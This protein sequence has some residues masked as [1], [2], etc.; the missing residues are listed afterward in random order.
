[1]WLPHRDYD[2]E[3][4]NTQLYTIAKTVNDAPRTRAGFGGAA[5]LRA[6]TATSPFNNEG[7]ILGWGFWWAKRARLHAV[8]QT[9]AQFP[10]RP[11][12][13]RFHGRFRQIQNLGCL[14][15]PPLLET[16]QPHH[17]SRRPPKTV[18]C[19]P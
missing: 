18:D 11:Q 4:T 9:F 13:T 5:T 12:K 6:G 8:R 17:C 1:M 16:E 14:F 19:F 15:R 10:P 7:S 3:R 2:L